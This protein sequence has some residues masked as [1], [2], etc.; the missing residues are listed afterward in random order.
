MAPVL[1]VPFHELLVRAGILT[2]DELPQAPRVASDES[3]TPE[4]LAATVG[5]HDPE[6][7]QQLT[8]FVAGLRAQ[9][10]QKES[11]QDNSK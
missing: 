1:K 5:I 2:E 6:L 10:A 11:R 7:V 8:T 3:H 9:Q 4:E